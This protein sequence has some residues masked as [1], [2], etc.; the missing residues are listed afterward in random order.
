MTIK[1]A[2]LKVDEISDDDEYE[3]FAPSTIRD[4]EKKFSFAYMCGK[5]WIQEIRA[6]G[7]LQKAKSCKVDCRLLLGILVYN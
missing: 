6:A 2:A 4:L 1:S 3:Q 5:F 7:D